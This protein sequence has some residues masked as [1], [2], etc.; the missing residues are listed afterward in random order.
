MGIGVIFGNHQRKRVQRATLRGVLGSEMEGHPSLILRSGS[1]T[2]ESEGMRQREPGSAALLVMFA[3]LSFLLMASLVLKGG[4]EE[5]A[6]EEEEEEA[7]F[8]VHNI[9]HTMSMCVS[10][11]AL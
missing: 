3:F 9:Y 2:P 1:G 4:R 10:A 11:T 8:T 7:P 5:K 6:G